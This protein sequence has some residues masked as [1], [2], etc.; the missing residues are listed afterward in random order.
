MPVLPVKIFAKELAALQALDP[1]MPVATLLRGLI[2]DDTPVQPDDPVGT[3]AG[4]FLLRV[5]AGTLEHLEAEASEDLDYEL[6]DLIR[7]RY[8]DLKPLPVK[9]VKV[10]APM[11]VAGRFT[12]EPIGALTEKI[13]VPCPAG[14][15]PRRSMRRWL[16]AYQIR[17]RADEPPVVVSG[18]SATIWLTSRELKRVRVAA[19]AEGIAPVEFLS[20]VIFGRPV[21]VEQRLEAA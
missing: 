18:R 1:D 11:M 15:T 7:V 3:V 16:S 4:V 2:G 20:R 21:P 10:A 8:L 14:I 12:L 19:D 6:Q 13:W 17:E 5:S 9:E